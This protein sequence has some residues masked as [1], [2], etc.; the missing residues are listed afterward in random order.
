[1]ASKNKP[2]SNKRFIKDIQKIMG[3]KTMTGSEIYREMDKLKCLPLSRDPMGYIRFTLSSLA[4]IFIREEGK[5]GSYHLSESN[6]FYHGLVQ[7]GCIICQRP[8][9]PPATMMCRICEGAYD[10]FNSKDPTTIG[11]MAWVAARART[12]LRRKKAK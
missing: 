8:V 7:V 9:K 10:R 4:D 12:F 1:M 5:R 11:L 2:N 3:N 6:P